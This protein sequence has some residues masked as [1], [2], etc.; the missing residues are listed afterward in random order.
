MNIGENVQLTTFYIGNELYGIE[1]M[2]VQEVTGRPIITPVP[3]APKFIRG[4]INLRG[5][6]ST[7]IGMSELMGTQQ[8]T[9]DEMTVVCKIEGSLVSL[10]VDSIGDVVEIESERFE[11]PPDT[12]PSQVRNYIKGIYKLNDSFLS[13]VDIDS[14]LKEIA[15]N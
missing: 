3:L 1:V 2:K 6:I 11:N 8:Q 13:V 14:I 4:L 7:A 5:Q 9:E 12:L 10:I 15:D